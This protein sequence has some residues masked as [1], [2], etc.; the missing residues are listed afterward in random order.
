[1]TCTIQS[2]TSLYLLAIDVVFLSS[3]YVNVPYTLVENMVKFPLRLF[4]HP[5][6]QSLNE[7]KFVFFGLRIDIIRDWGV[8]TYHQEGLENTFPMVYSMPSEFQIC[9]RKP[10]NTNMQSFSDCK[11]RWSKELQWENDCCSFLPCFLLL[12]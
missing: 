11:S 3:K 4:D 10:K 9:S 8:L 2:Y 5:N 6:M 7:C 1:M 12:Q